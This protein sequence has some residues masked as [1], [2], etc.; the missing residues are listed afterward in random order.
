MKVVGRLMTILSNQLAYK[1]VQVLSL[2]ACVDKIGFS[3][4]FAISEICS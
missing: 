2:S 4:F 1:A 3:P